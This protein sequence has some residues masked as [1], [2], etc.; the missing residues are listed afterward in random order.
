LECSE[1]VQILIFLYVMEQLGAEEIS[2]GNTM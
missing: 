2:R 1:K